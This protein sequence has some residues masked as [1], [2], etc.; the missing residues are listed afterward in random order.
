MDGERNAMAVGRNGE[1]PGHGGTDNEAAK[2]WHNQGT[3]RI[4]KIK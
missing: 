3:K 4:Y 1:E 2:T